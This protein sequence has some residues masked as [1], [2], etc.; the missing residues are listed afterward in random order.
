MFLNRSKE[1]LAENRWVWDHEE[2]PPSFGGLFG[3][4]MQIEGYG[5]LDVQLFGR[6]IV[7]GE[8]MMFELRIWD[9]E[10]AMKTRDIRAVWPN[11]TS[12]FINFME[13]GISEDDAGAVLTF[14]RFVRPCRCARNLD[15]DCG[16]GECIFCAM[17]WSVTDEPCDD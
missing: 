2:V 16:M 3:G 4:L 14:R 9:L 12:A 10:R 8:L 11:G 6:C 13:T 5:Q 17:K 1:W 7:T 15:G